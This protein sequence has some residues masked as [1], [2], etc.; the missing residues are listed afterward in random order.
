[1]AYHLHSEELDVRIA[2]PGEDYKGARFDWS[3]LVT[4]VT[5]RKTGM[6]FCGVENETPGQGSGG[7]G[8]CNEFGI[9]EA[10]GYSDAAV[11]GRFPK[12][13]IGLL[14]KLDED[15][16]F[17]MLHYP[18]KPFMIHREGDERSVRFTVEPEEVNGYACRLEKTLTL[19]GAKLSIAYRL[20]N[21]GGQPI[22]T[23]EYVHNF[24]RIGSYEAGPDYTLTWGGA[25]EV[26]SPEVGN[27]ADLKLDE[28]QITWTG[29]PEGEFYSKLTVPTIDSPFT[30]ELR[31]VPSGAYVRESGDFPIDRVAMWGHAAVISP[32]V[33][34][35]LSLQPGETVAWTRTYEFFAE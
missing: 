5:W 23:D 6:T 13:G 25:V 31:H 22:E 9:E 7:I 30:W 14:Q 26:E 12:L 3:G 19:E 15:P 27:R 18:I 8:I 17:F 16:Y 29:R 4:Q 2:D 1:M 34:I 33:F 21:T 35:R 24:L 11:G 20:T 28:K 32:E 10:L